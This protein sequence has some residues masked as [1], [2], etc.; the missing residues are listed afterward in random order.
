MSDFVLTSA[1][2]VMH[3]N[4][5]EALRRKHPGHWALEDPRPVTPA[6][7]YATTAEAPTEVAIPLVSSTKLL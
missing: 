4:N 3:R 2:V 1:G 5:F 6:E 7:M